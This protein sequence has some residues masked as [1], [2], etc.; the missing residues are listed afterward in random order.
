MK[1]IAH[2][3]ESLR[4]FWSRRQPRERRILA[5]GGALA[6]PLILVFGIL[7]PLQDARQ[8][9]DSTVAKERQRTA[10]MRAMQTE[11]ERLS[12]LPA[13]P[14]PT[15]PQLV[16]AIEASARGYFASPAITA[17]L[18]GETVKLSLGSMPFERLVGWLDLIRQSDHVTVRSASIHPETGNQ[19]SA[20]LV[21]TGAAP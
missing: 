12:A 7:L 4:A 14:S 21:L 10:N 8:R 20:L 17:T 5:L 9:L 18:E 15:G 6:L 1:L 2:A 19:C 3:R 16:A 11:I 13:K